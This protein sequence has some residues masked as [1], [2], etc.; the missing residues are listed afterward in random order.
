MTA[1]IN[2]LPPEILH[3]ILNECSKFRGRYWAREKLLSVALTLINCRR[4]C[5]LW[6]DMIRT[7]FSDEMSRFKY[8]VVGIENGDVCEDEL[9]SEE[10]WEEWEE[11][12][13]PIQYIRRRFILIGGKE[14]V[15]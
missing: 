10:D 6:N 2:D 11:C 5:H 1:A 9:K 3:K 15:Q 12:E 7:R 14:K 8:L 4:V 13:L